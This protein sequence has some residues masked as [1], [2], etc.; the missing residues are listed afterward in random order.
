M[1]NLAQLT[2]YD[3]MGNATGVNPAVADDT[4]AMPTNS[5]VVVNNV[6]NKLFRDD[7]Q[8]YQLWPEKVARS[9]LTAPHDALT[10]KINPYEVD[11]DTGELRTSQEMIGRSLDMAS[12]AGTGGL[13]GA[14]EGAV[15][16]ATPSL[17]PALKYKDR[18]Y[19]G[20]EG[21][22]HMDVIPDALYPEFQKMAMSGEDISHYNFGFVNDKGHFMNR[23]DALKYG[24]DSGI[25]DPQ[26]GKFGALTSTM[27]ADSSKPGTAI[28]S[29]NN[30]FNFV[31][32]EGD[33][34]K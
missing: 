33:P 32:V 3:A 25:I 27:M 34:F 13:A 11:P 19:K 8:R 20:K 4:G 17:R 23:D 14:E 7:D 9:A 30:K 31:P 5:S 21:Q 16:N 1:P 22:G 26:A 2:D 24:I 10:G 15:L 29:Q 28:E 6:I 12:F 18:L